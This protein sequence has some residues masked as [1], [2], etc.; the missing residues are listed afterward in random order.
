LVDDVT[1]L[2][3]TLAELASYIQVYGC[4]VKGVVVLVNAGRNPELA[5]KAKFV[6]LIKERFDDEFTEVLGIEPGVLTVNEAQYLA[7]F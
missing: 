6:Q 7:G 2:G 4:I 1:S 5:P 3:G